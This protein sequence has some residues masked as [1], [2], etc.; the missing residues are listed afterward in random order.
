M[1]LRVLQMILGKEK[2]KCGARVI[3]NTL[4]IDHKEVV[5]DLF[6]IRNSDSW[7]R[8]PEARVVVRIYLKEKGLNHTSDDVFVKKI[9]N[10]IDKVSDLLM[11]G[12]KWW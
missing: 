3:S 4:D 9:S 8:T 5:S 2:L 11:Y 6:K 1:R 7:M 12:G 10:E